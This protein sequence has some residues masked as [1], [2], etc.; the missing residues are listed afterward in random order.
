MVDDSVLVPVSLMTVAAFLYS[1]QSTLVK[2]TA[3]HT[4]LWTLVCTRGVVGTLCA[5]A[6]CRCHVT[7]DGESNLVLWARAL[8]GGV[9]VVSGFFALRQGSLVQ[10]TT[11][12]S[13]APV[14]TFI[15]SCVTERRT[16]S[17]TF[18]ETLCTTTCTV[19]VCFLATYKGVENNN[20]YTGSVLA[21]VSAVSQACVN[22]LV[23]RCKKSP[24]LVTTFFGMVGS[25]CV[26]LPGLLHEVK[27]GELGHLDS[28]GLASTLPVGFVSFLAQLL[29][30]QALVQCEGWY[31]TTLRYTEVIFSFVWD[32]LL[33]HSTLTWQG[34]TGCVLIAASCLVCVV[35]KYT[36]NVTQ[37]D[38][39]H[40][41][42]C[43]V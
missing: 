43:C 19:G 25:V 5:L 14:L 33:F 11:I 36:S 35:A 15:A 8:L 10:T 18:I 4:G 2:L 32:L 21:L 31:V 17:L 37:V 34:T 13:S 38:Q 30:T 27:A 3:Q 16:G 12:L 39:T 26:S 41:Q 7:I 9:T 28:R 22:V 29:K 23:K 24:P 20:Y 1:V 40:R 42:D 6:G